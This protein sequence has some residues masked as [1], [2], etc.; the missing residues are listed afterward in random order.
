M[1]L[2]LAEASNTRVAVADCQNWT[3][4]SIQ[5]QRVS[6]Q[7]T[8]SVFKVCLLPRCLL[9]LVFPKMEA[10]CFSEASVNLYQTARRH[11]S[12]AVT[13]HRHGSSR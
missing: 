8:A 5:G 9:D 12:E 6:E 7:H 13:V 1:K 3:G 10:V 4:R 2:T 11:I